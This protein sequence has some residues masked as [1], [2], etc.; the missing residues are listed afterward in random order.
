MFLKLLIAFLWEFLNSDH[1]NC[2][3]HIF[4]LISIDS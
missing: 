4:D 3:L 1:S 2:F